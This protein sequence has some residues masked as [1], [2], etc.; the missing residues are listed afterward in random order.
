MTWGTVAIAAGIGAATGAGSAA[1]Q[2][3]ETDEILKRALIGG[4]TGAVT[5]GI[6]GPAT[7]GV[8]E[9]GT[10]LGEAL[11]EEGIKTASDQAMTDALTQEAFNPLTEIGTG[12]NPVPPAGIEQIPGAAGATPFPP[13]GIQTA[14]GPATS[15]VA[16]FQSDQSTI[17]AIKNFKPE[18]QTEFVPQDPFLGSVPTTS[19]VPVDPAGV[20]PKAG[21]S[22]LVGESYAVGRDPTAGYA[23]A[24]RGIVTP[25]VMPQTPP[26]NSFVDGLKSIGQFAKDHPF[27]TGA[28]LYLGA[29]ALGAF[30][31]KGYSAPEKK[32]YPNPNPLSA[33]FNSN[34]QPTPN[35]YKPMTYQEGGITQAFQQNNDAESGVNGDDGVPRY[36]RGEL[37]TSDERKGDV[38][39]ATQRFLN[40]YD[41]AAKY[42]PPPD[43]PS[44][45]IFRDNNPST[46]SKSALEA[47][48]IRR[49]AMENRAY[50]KTGANYKPASREMGE[51]DF[52][53]IGSKDKKNRGSDSDPVLAANGGIMQANLG[54]YASGGNPRLLK[55]PGDGMSDNI[56]ATIGGRQPA[57]LADGEFVVPADVVSHLGNG[58]TDAGAK[59][60]HEMMNQVRMD[61]T[62]RKKQ[63]PAVK[64]KK[65]IPK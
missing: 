35:V 22:D 26:T 21:T 50:V 39:G 24:E 45:G 63:A 2:G 31:Q 40:M 28:G 27:Y 46:S 1:I 30:E 17:D 9:V 56:P 25:S 8:T 47:A 4:A 33:N 52:T 58:S 43:M 10:G 13:A 36:Y 5:G 54:G 16:Q 55:G 15:D 37:A 19:S 57:R 14:S 42:T 3:K 23:G 59:R 32:K 12:I 65:Y 53:I 38:Y 11:T 29:N 6:S 34:A 61:R 44:G 60:L 64:A 20:T 51:L 7:S 48:D 18:L 62:G 49:K 41:P